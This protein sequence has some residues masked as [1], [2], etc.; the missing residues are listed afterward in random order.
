MIL[1]LLLE[2]FIFESEHPSMMAK[3]MEKLTSLYQ[4]EEIIRGDIDALKVWFET[5]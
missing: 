2:S 1:K 5:L 4:I 3:Y